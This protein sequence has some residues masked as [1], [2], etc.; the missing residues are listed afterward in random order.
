[1]DLKK[2]FF[3]KSVNFLKKFKIKFIKNLS[4]SLYSKKVVDAST[5]DLE[6]LFLLA[7]KKN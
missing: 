3:L 6:D 1:M 4:K 7:K 5:S 2:N